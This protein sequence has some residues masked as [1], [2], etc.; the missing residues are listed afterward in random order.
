M[1]TDTMI[2]QGKVWKF[3]DEINTDL[4]MPNFVTFQSELFE[5]EAAK[6]VM[7]AIRPEW[8]MLVN[9][10][11]ILI[12]GKNFGCG[13]SRPA[14]KLLKTLGI[15]V[16]VADSVARLFFLN[17]IHI[18]LP[19]VICGGASQLFEEGDL[20]SINVQTGVVKNVTQGREIHGAAL[21][22]DSPPDKILR[23]GGL[24]LFMKKENLI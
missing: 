1:N 14:S 17:A 24:E 23:A 19:V 3:G 9:Q 22:F 12:A 15:S 13:S 16:V 11:D 6:Y 20:A 21:P 8:P 5:Q 4:I 7:F 10:G 18:G 2:F